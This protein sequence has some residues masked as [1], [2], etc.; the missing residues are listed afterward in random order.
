MEPICYIL[1]DLQKADTGG[2][3]KGPRGG[4]RKKVGGSWVYKKE[5]SGGSKGGSKDKK[6][7]NWSKTKDGGYEGTGSMAGR[8]S[9]SKDEKGKW[10]L[11]LDGK[12]HDMP[13]KGASFEHAEGV[14][15]GESSKDK[16][17]KSQSD[18]K[19][20]EGA[21]KKKGNGIGEDD[22]HFVSGDGFAE[23]AH[24]AIQGGGGLTPAHDKEKVKA[25]IG[26]LEAK[27]KSMTGKNSET[28]EN[29]LNATKNELKALKAS[30]TAKHPNAGKDSAHGKVDDHGRTERD[31]KGDKKEGHGEKPQ[32]VDDHEHP[33]GVKYDKGDKV[34]S[35]EAL[36][37]LSVG[38]ILQMAWNGIKTAVKKL[39]D[40]SW[41]GASSG[42]S[43]GGGDLTSLL[44]LIMGMV[45]FTVRVAAVGV[46]ATAAMG[47]AGGKAA[48]AGAGKL[49]EK[50]GYK[51][52]APGAP[53]KSK[54]PS[55]GMRKAILYVLLEPQN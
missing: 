7:F 18:S 28:S 2:W 34:V 1:D 17:G 32:E 44:K 46:T 11:T 38:S 5:G 51:Q 6:D 19:N 37:E 16:D 42:G 31:H 22:H 26:E 35:T 45:G 23:K 47:A 40:G 30:L 48:A 55:D 29:T 39:E 50:A 4:T 9:I 10:S 52:P 14:I 41:A 3:E 25:K 8:A 12:K 27:L 43:G 24:E 53:P 15:K 36:K 33:K 54:G 20:K 49:A 21:G 13:S